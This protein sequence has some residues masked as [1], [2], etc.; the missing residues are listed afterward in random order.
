MLAVFLAAVGLLVWPGVGSDSAR[1]PG[2]GTA[3]GS[4]TTSSTPSTAPRTTPSRTVAVGPVGPAL[5][6][7]VVLYTGTVAGRLRILRTSTSA[8]GTSTPVTPTADNFE[9]T[10]SRDRRTVAYV[11][12]T[13]PKAGPFRIRL[14]GSDGTGDRPLFATMPSGCAKALRPTFSPDGTRLLVRCQ[15]AGSDVTTLR[16]YALD[17]TPVGPALASGTLTPAS[18]RRDGKQI[19]FGQVVGGRSRL[20]AVNADGTPHVVGL[21]PFSAAHVDTQPACSPVDD[22]I[23]FQ[24]VPASGNALGT[25]YLLRPGTRDATRLTT[26]DAGEHD[27]SWS[28]DGTKIAYERYRGTAHDIYVV[29]ASG[30][31]PTELVGG[32]GPDF[33]PAWSNR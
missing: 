9:A 28:P 21:T 7:D 1:T 19:V 6:P 25:L 24:R 8:P 2:G 14:I 23:V 31:S 18:Y 29:D 15:A 20:A 22:S 32:T 27:P 16:Q 3:Q 5:Q 10:V 11:Q 33:Q 17:G 30:A 13:D 26:E 4:G 12:Y